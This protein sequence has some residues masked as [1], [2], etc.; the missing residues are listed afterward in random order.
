MTS[1]MPP[2]DGIEHR[3]PERGADPRLP[4]GFQNAVVNQS[5]LAIALNVTEPTIKSY[6]TKGMPSL[7][8][9]TNGRSYEYDLQ[10]CLLWKLDYDEEREAYRRFADDQAIQASLL[11]RN[12]DQDPDTPVLTARQ[13]REESEADYQRNR[14]AEARGKLVRA[15]RV[16]A[17]FE[18]MF[19]II[20]VSEKT[21]PDYAEAELGLEPDQVVKL[22]KRSKQK[23]AELQTKFRSLIRGGA[24]VQ[25]LRPEQDRM[26]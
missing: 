16:T 11:F 17:L 9:G 4:E 6:R 21:L 20:L 8:D 7:T 3:L 1:T 24:Q 13:V 18:A 26:I 22:E 12:L 15:D 2:D 10:E 14:A 23:L 5:R 25:P 19:E